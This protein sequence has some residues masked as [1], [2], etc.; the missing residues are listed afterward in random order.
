LNFSC[1]VYALN[2]LLCYFLACYSL[3]FS[4]LLLEKIP[5]LL[6]IC[7]ELNIKAKSQLESSVYCTR[8]PTMPPPYFPT[9]NY[10][11]QD[12]SH[13]INGLS[14][15][16]PRDSS[17]QWPTKSVVLEELPIRELLMM[18]L[19]EEG[20]RKMENRAKTNDQLFD[21]YYN[22]ITSTHTLSLSMKQN[23]F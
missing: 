11:S 13:N 20:R 3:S 21:D 14:R 1:Q 16:K 18:L 8:W 22:L 23:G 7:I 9:P 17:P 5:P 6:S 10:K 15:A 12:T 19:G 4:S 2:F